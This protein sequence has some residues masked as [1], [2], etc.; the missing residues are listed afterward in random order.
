VDHYRK[1]A[2]RADFEEDGAQFIEKNLTDGKLLEVTMAAE[3]LQKS[4]LS[5]VESLPIE[6]REAF[7]L[8]EE[9]GFSIREIADI[10]TITQEAAKSRLR[11]AYRKLRQQLTDT[12]GKRA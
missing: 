3:E 9:V 1:T 10:Q 4:I 11:Y 12:R 5:A 8:R 7:Y 2:R 6:Q